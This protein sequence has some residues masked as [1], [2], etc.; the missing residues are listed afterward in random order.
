[1]S[2]LTATRVREIF[3][4]CLFRAGELTNGKPTKPFTHV[5][6]ITL[7][8]G[9]CSERVEVHRPEIHELCEELSDQFKSGM[10]FLDM[11]ID[12]Y[13]RQ[14]GE[15]TNMQELMLL[16]IAAGKMKYCLPKEFWDSLPGNV[17]YIMVV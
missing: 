7:D 9:F 6:G 8:V 13:N 17:P 3:F 14:W 15:H 11:C 4:D 5:K 2:E 1:M 16:G 10:S 12:K